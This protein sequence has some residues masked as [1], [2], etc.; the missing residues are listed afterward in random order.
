MPNY[1]SFLLKN[2]LLTWKK[3]ASGPLTARREGSRSPGAVS[4]NARRNAN[5]TVSKAT[6]I[7]LM[8]QT[9]HFGRICT[10][11]NSLGEFMYIEVNSI[12]LSE[13]TSPQ[14]KK[15]EVYRFYI[16][17]WENK[18]LARMI[19]SGLGC[20][21]Q[22]CSCLA[23]EWFN[24]TFRA[25]YSVLLSKLSIVECELVR[26]RLLYFC[27]RQC[28]YFF[29]RITKNSKRLRKIRLH[30]LFQ[31]IYSLRVILDSSPSLAYSLI[32]LLTHV[33]NHACTY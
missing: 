5:E 7:Q 29:P 22:T 2:G 19:L 11:I 3:G 12:T 17:V 32:H 4:Q 6:M 18:L 8:R 13:T 26:K 20:R 24:S 31:D 10:V 15:V 25:S 30:S 1:E 9:Q 28:V 33:L 27:A 21:L 14:V 23:T 16:A